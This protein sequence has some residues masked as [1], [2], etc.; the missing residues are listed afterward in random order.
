MYSSFMLIGYYIIVLH[1]VYE[2][3]SFISSVK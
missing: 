1:S 3:M 2:H